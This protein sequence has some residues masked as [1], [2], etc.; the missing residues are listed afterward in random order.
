MLEKIS[1][2]GVAARLKDRPYPAAAIRE[3][4]RFDGFAN[5]RRMMR[6]IVDHEDTAPFAANFLAPFHSRKCAKP[7]DKLCPLDTHGAPKGVNRQ[8]VLHVVP[9]DDRGFE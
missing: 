6:E 1:F 9:A 3:S 5:R 7:I 2:A 4:N 8:G